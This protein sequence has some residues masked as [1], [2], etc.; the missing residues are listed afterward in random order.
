M[1]AL[2][3]HPEPGVAG[4]G[5]FSCLFAGSGRLCDPC[6]GSWGRSLRRLHRHSRHSDDVARRHRQFEVLINPFDST[7]HGLPDPAHGLT[8][9]KMFFDSFSDCLADC[10]AAVSGSSPIDG[11]ASD[12]RGVA[13]HMGCHISL[14]TC[15]D[16]VPRVVGLVC[17]H[18]LGMFAG[19]RVEHGQRRNSLA[20]SVRMGDH[21]AHNEAR[22]K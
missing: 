18:R 8:P 15:C 2:R 20:H 5:D 7:V 22:A 11:T 12:A 10:V 9:S 3:V 6:V 1:H 17:R 16:E 4:R 21:R 19:Q 13:G 14:A